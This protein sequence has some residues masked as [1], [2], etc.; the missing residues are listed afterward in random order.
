MSELIHTHSARVRTTDG[1]E[2]VARIYGREERPGGI[3][4][5]WLEFHPTNAGHPV[6]RT[7]TETSQPDFKALDYW[8]GGLQPLYLDGALHRARAR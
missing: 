3:W 2:Y 4:L 7:G 6:L 5:G 1:V 8:A